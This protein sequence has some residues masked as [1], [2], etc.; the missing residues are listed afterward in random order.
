MMTSRATIGEKMNTVSDSG[1]GVPELTVM[2]TFLDRTAMDAAQIFEEC[3][4][5]KARFWGMKEEPLSKDEMKKLYDCMKKCNKTTFL[6]VV[7][8]TEEEGLDGAQ[9]AKY[10]GVDVLL[11]TMYSDRIC[12]FCAENN[13]KYMP[14]V[15]KITGRPSVLQG[16][17]DEIIDEAKALLDKGVYGF[18]LLG[19]RYKGDAFEL[20]RRFV[21][22]VNAPVCL[23]GSIDSFD[24]LDEVKNINPWSF[25]IGTAFFEKKF[26]TG[27]TEQIDKV[28]DYM[29]KSQ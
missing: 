12:D 23:A 18:D 28:Y 13:I 20:N 17:V 29:R 26:G 27:W 25:T 8:Y 19:Y 22:E 11:G 9:L 7:A 16:T 6:E 24:K 15:G 1:I 21:K 4:N 3:K 10:C 2:L 5:S 14:F